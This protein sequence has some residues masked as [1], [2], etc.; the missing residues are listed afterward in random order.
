MNEDPTVTREPSERQRADE[1]WRDVGRQFEELGESLSRAFRAAW[2]SEETQQHVQSL[3]HGLEKMVRE[4][5]R[6]VKEAGESYQGK[7]VRAEAEKAAGSLRRAGERTWQETRP[8]LVSALTTLN[9]ELQ[10]LIDDLQHEPGSGREPP[11][12]QSSRGGTGSPSSDSEA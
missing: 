7:R 4:V 3:Q 8:Q 12:D 2:E 10:S 9:S 6:A 1:A 11:E 5:D